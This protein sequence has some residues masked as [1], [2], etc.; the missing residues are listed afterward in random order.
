M[1]GPAGIKE[2]DV[3]WVQQ[4]RHAKPVKDKLVVVVAVESEFLGL[5]INSSIPPFLRDN[6]RRLKCFAAVAAGE[7]RFLSHNSFIAC[8]RL[9]EFTPQE[10]VRKRGRLSRAARDR[11]KTAAQKCP[12]LEKKQKILINKAHAG[13][14]GDDA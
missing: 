4:C 8:D 14:A 12:V 13:Y 3:F 7:H 6:P 2:W 5:F 9:F 1:S 11:V 10:L